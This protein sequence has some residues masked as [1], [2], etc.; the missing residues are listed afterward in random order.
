MT[1]HL[2]D[3]GTSRYLM[4][5]VFSAFAVGVASFAA[6]LTI[7]IPLIRGLLDRRDLL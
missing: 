2:P 3:P 5:S 6:F 1:F 7:A 4:L